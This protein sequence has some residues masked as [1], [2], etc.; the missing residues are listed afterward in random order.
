MS[1][2]VSEV[3]VRRSR[4]GQPTAHTWR[5][6]RG[7]VVRAGVVSD[8]AQLRYCN[9]TVLAAVCVPDA[10]APRPRAAGARGAANN[11]FQDKRA[12]RPL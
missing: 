10:V 11:I 4:A 9:I 1:D 7:H 8:L 6:K 2:R 3:R 12:R 5:L